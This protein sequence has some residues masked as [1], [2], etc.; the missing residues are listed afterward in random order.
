MGRCIE[1]PTSGGQSRYLAMFTDASGERRSAGTFATEREATQ[2]WLDAEAKVRAGKGSFL[3]RGRMKLREYVEEHWLPNQTIEPTTIA[4]YTYGLNRYILPVFGEY[5]LMDIRTADVKQ[6]VTRL[7]SQGIKPSNRKSI[8]QALSSV[9]SSAVDDE[10]IESNPCFRVRNET[11]EQKPLKIITPQQFE[12]FYEALPDAMSKLL[13][14]TAIETGMRWS[15]LTELRVKDFDENQ[16]A[17]T[18]C[19]AAVP[20]APQFHPEADKS[21]YVK[22]YPKNG[23]YRYIKI[24]PDLA[25]KIRSHIGQH[26]LKDDDLLF[27]YTGPIQEK[28]ANSTAREFGDLGYTEPNE[29]GNKYAH[30]TMTAYTNGKCRCEHCR[31]VMAAYRRKRRANG[32]DNPRQPRLWHTDGHIPQ[33]WFRRQVIK[34]ALERAGLKVDIK[35]HLLR[36]AHASWLLNGGADLVVVKERLGHDS[37]TTTKRYLHTLDN[38][39]ETALTALDKVRGRNPAANSDQLAGMPRTLGSNTAASAAEL[40]AQM[41]ALQTELAKHF[42]TI[43]PDGSPQ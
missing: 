32:K 25:G 9:L 43:Q 8:K 6:W 28:P 18:V 17:F 3:I 2:A 5:S 33:Q 21:I 15:E 27:W 26:H 38:A 20:I 22:A 7:K 41:A 16:D 39:D 31:A 37:I 23:K 12:Q 42:G 13:V 4:G 1:R 36:H 29:N 34:P 30:G 24:G 10:Y 14:E 35:M 19:R 11:I 40:L